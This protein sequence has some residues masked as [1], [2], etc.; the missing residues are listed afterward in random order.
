MF[1]FLQKLSSLVALLSLPALVFI[2]SVSLAEGAGLGTDMWTRQF[3]QWGLFHPH[4]NFCDSSTEVFVNVGGSGQGYCIEKAER[5]TDTFMNARE[6][7][8][9]DRKRLPEPAEF[10]SACGATGFTNDSTAFEWVSNFTHFSYYNTS[11]LG[12]GAF[13]AGGGGSCQRGNSGYV[14][15]YTTGWNTQQFRCVR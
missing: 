15:H 3:E 9:Q 1:R 8:A 13:T 6:T 10:Y 7:C 12:I 2:P 4:A 5:G 14:G 11:N